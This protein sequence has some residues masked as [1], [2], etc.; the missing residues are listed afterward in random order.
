MNRL[1]VIVGEDRVTDDDLERELYSQEVANLPPEVVYVFNVRPDVVVRPSSTPE[2]VNVVALAQELEIPIT[3][4]GAGTLGLGGSMPSKGGIMLDLSTMNRIIDVDP[5]TLSATVEAGVTWEE[6]RDAARAKGL[7][8]GAYPSSA[9]SATVG[10]WLSG[11]GVGIGS[12]KYG[13]AAD[14]VRWLEVV[15]AD[16]RVVESGFRGVM[17][18]ASGYSLTNMFV[19]AEGT[20]GVITRATIKLRPRPGDVVPSAYAFKGMKEASRAILALTRSPVVPYSISF[21]DGNHLA[22]LEELGME[23]PDAAG[24]VVTVALEGHMD[25]IAVTDAETEAAMG[26]AGGR[27]LSDEEAA[28]SWEN[29]SYEFR[30][31]R[32]G[33]GLV[34]GSVFVPTAR[35]EEAV[36]KVYHA[37]EDLGMKAGITGLVADRNTVDILPYYIVDD[38]KMLKNIAVMSFVK[39]LTDIALAH[40]GRPVGVGM[41]FAQNLGRVHGEGAE[42]MRAMKAALDPNDIMNPGKVVKMGTRFDLAIPTTA[43]GL[44]MDFLSALK[45]VLPPDTEEGEL[46]GPGGQ[47]WREGMTEGDE[48]EWVHG[49]REKEGGAKGRKGGR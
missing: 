2:V 34:P 32:L 48:I 31:K 38:R 16:G 9:L 39:R 20:L 46:G 12:Y 5:D 25:E 24:A 23:V 41:W 22:N 3:P 13:P 42:V 19:G 8:V 18:N 47:G 21:V 10:G 6:L 29:R 4:R 33:P 14:Q 35:L 43:A 26:S 28:E 1:A 40:G 27:R 45:K 7:R 15:L 44:G 17:D 36:E 37:I 11:G 30:V 49:K